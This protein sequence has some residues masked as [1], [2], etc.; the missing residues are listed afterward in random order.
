MKTRTIHH[1]EELDGLV[2]ELL[3]ALPRGEGASVLT[4]QGDLGA[5]KTALVKA[6]ARTLGIAETVTSPTFVI[7]KS[8][9]IHAHA[10]FDTLVHID[11][12]RIDDE[13]ELRVIGLEALLNTP[14]TLIALE[15]PERIPEAL[16]KLGH[17]RIL[18]VSI[19]LGEAQER[20]VTYD[21]EY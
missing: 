16:G 20:I 3:A 9:S 19:T 21:K 13:D 17:E 1:V 11:A 8:Y 7:M 10:H 12:Y 6:L 14:R 5:G 4:L 15:W 18:A 2:T